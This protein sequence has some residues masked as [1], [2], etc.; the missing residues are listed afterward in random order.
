MWTTHGAAGGIE[1]GK[2]GWALS[3]QIH[4]LADVAEWIE[5]QGLEVFGNQLILTVDFPNLSDYL[6]AVSQICCPKHPKRWL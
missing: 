6:A 3:S 5:K 1:P 2:L 4:A